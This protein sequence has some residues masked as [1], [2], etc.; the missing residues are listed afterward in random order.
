M[1][2][3]ER[4]RSSSGVRTG[5]SPFERKPPV[6]RCRCPPPLDTAGMGGESRCWT[7]PRGRRD[8]SHVGAAPNQQCP[9]PFSDP[10]APDPPSSLS[11]TS[12]LTAVG[13]RR[14]MGCLNPLVHTEAV[15]ASNAPRV[16]AVAW[17][18]SRNVQPPAAG[19][20]TAWSGGLR[21]GA[22]VAVSGLGGVAVRFM[23]GQQ[24]RWTGRAWAGHTVCQRARCART[25][26]FVEESE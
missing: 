13:G 16:A 17:V 24:W 4:S 25:C 14:P 18:L 15:T 2:T 10:A 5:T 8:P 7:C 20:T 22:A 12:G 3:W 23:T 21:N 19:N 1:V 6:P 9:A 11:G 26:P